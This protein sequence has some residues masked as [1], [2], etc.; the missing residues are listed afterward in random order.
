M[1]KSYINWLKDGWIKVYLGGQVWKRRWDRHLLW[2]EQQYQFFW[3]VH[4]RWVDRVLRASWVVHGISACIKGAKGGVEDGLNRAVL[5][6][7]NITD[8]SIYGWIR[9]MK[10]KYVDILMSWI[11]L[12]NIWK[13]VFEIYSFKQL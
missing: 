10:T 9:C 11:A 1:V 5:W 8:G 4:M 12:M 3:W 6:M 2:T 13:G 7:V